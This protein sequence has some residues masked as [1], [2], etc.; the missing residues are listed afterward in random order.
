MIVMMMR[1]R[2]TEHRI[3]IRM[4]FAPHQKGLLWNVYSCV[5]STESG[6]VEFQ[7]GYRTYIYDT[8]SMIPYIIRIDHR[9]SRV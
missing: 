4:E 1:S 3:K 6:T 9:R 5:S 2:R 8:D 7:T